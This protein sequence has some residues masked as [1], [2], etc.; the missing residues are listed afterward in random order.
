MAK[1]RSPSPTLPLSRRVG[2]PHVQPTSKEV[3]AEH[4]ELAGT[5]LSETSHIPSTEDEDEQEVGQ[6][7]REE[8]REDVGSQA[9][10][11][12]GRAQEGAPQVVAPQRGISRIP[13]ASAPQGSARPGSPAGRNARGGF[14]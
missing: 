8:G 1:P 3:S 5:L 4:A 12:E 7:A 13:D 11:P 9:S 2:A 6:E 14:V 10:G